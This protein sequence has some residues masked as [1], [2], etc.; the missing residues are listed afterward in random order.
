MHGKEK[1]F[2]VLD[3]WSDNKY[4]ALSSLQG[5]KPVGLTGLFSPK[6]YCE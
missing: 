3:S 4:F 6:K 2:E 1:P 5:L